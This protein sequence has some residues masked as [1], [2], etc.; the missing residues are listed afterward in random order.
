MTFLAPR[1]GLFAVF[2]LVSL[3]LHT[4]FF[5][6]SE[7]RESK[8]R[9]RI[10][11]EQSIAELTLELKAP[12]AN[13]D[14]ISMSV[15]A[16]KYAKD[17][18]LSFVGIYDAKD[19]LIV[20]VGS[21]NDAGISLKGSV[22]SGSDALGSVVVKAP[23]I[24]RAKIISEH[25]LFLLGALAL[26][27][28]LWLIY[29]YIARP[30]SELRDS[31][32]KKVRLELLDKGLLVQQTTQSL[33]ATA[34]ANEDVN[35]KGEDKDRGKAVPS[36]NSFLQKAR[37]QQEISMGDTQANTHDV[38]DTISDQAGYM[39]QILLED[40]NQ[41]LSTVSHDNKV[42]YFALCNQLLDR[43]L[44]ELLNL[45][46]LVGV[47][48]KVIKYYDDKGAKVVINGNDR[49]KQAT[50]AVFL[51][52]LMLMLNQAVYDKHREI[53]RPAWQIRTAVSS[54]QHASVVL[55]LTNK[56]KETPLI[57]IDEQ[58]QEEVKVYVELVR[59]DNPK[60]IHERESRSLASVSRA[61]A[62]RL[63]QA[64]EKVLL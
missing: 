54:V 35:D 61:T 34:K 49:A 18:E 4:L 11:A 8:D 52:K 5:V 30:T 24:S 57:L 2:I 33:T 37:I 28:I 32:A 19:I 56:R 38:T 27:M 45:T 47:Q 7:E 22:V 12:L 14:R 21:E 43:S 13:N 1:Q 50:A 15:L 46:L 10:S 48:A 31:I 3:C 44:K 16:D 58:A 64:M 17:Y 60:S 62:E 59:L 25:W 53:K 36:V 9:Y 42:A 55:G 51:S 29:G 39:V 20:P 41:L 63:R 40:P 26:H 23:S 6:L